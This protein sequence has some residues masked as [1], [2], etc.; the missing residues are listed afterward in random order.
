MSRAPAF[1]KPIGCVPIFRAPTDALPPDMM[2]IRLALSSLEVPVLDS[3]SDPIVALGQLHGDL[4]NRP[5]RQSHRCE[6]GAS[7]NP[8]GDGDGD[9]VRAPNADPCRKAPSLFVD[10]TKPVNPLTSSERLRRPGD[11]DLHRSQ[12]RHRRGIR[13][14]ADP[15]RNGPLRS[16]V[17]RWCGTVQSAAR[18]SSQAATSASSMAPPS[19]AARSATTIMCFARRSGTVNVAGNCRRAASR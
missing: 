3:C 19:P 4:A 9:S 15:A 18:W 14:R 2:I 5:R 12:P 13:C 8:S 11:V 16:S 10:L 7:P 17:R 1:V 6:F